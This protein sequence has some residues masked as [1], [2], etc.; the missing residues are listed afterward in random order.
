MFIIFITFIE[1]DKERFSNKIIVQLKL[2]TLSRD[3]I[4]YNIYM[5]KVVAIYLQK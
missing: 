2:L 1:I 5:V 4:S 3:K